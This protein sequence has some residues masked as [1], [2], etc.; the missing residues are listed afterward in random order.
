MTKEAEDLG[1]QALKI[2]EKIQGNTHSFTLTSMDNL[3]WT[4]RLQGRHH[5]ACILMNRC[6]QLSTETLGIDHPI[7]RPHLWALTILENKDEC[8]TCFRRK[9]F[10]EA[11]GKDCHENR[12]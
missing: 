6:A 7:T 8:S 2:R 11:F 3:A 4:L 9:E 5:E 12:G 10:K 1:M